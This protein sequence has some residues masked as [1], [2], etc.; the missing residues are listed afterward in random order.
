V[1]KIAIIDTSIDIDLI[2]RKNIQGINLCGENARNTTKSKD[3]EISHGTLCAM[4]LNH[5]ALDYELINI[6]I[7]DDNKEKVYGDIE[8][9]AEALKVCR[10]LE[11]DVVS[12]SAVS[13]ILSDSRNIYDI[14]RKLSEKAL[15]VSALD[16]AQYITVPTSYPHVLGVQHDYA[17]LLLPGDIKSCVDNPFGIDVYANC[18]F[19]F[20]QKYESGPS[21]SLAVPVVAAYIGNLLN[22]GVTKKEAESILRNLKQYP[23]DSGFYKRYLPEKRTDREIPIIFVEDDSNEFCIELMDSFLLKFD[24]QTSTLSGCERH[25]D[26]RIQ[27]VKNFN[28][29]QNELRF[30]E[31][32][33]KTDLIFIVA[34]ECTLPEIC[35]KIDIDIKL[36]RQ[37]FGKTLVQHEY[38]QIIESNSKLV[39]KLHELLTNQENTKC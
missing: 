27:T 25:S 21:N 33:Y 9:L 8:R 37:E 29:I 24:V 1:S 23:L 31:N 14:S 30:M 5:C 18:D 7:F 34:N 38:G 32:H 36:L 6:R 39:D 20:L 16:N 2:D 26:I 10:E 4:V 3:R 11:V 12:L 17:G 35:D 13:S 19:D 28:N 15:V 22:E